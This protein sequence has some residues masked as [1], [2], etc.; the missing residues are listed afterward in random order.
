MPIKNSIKSCLWEVLWYFMEPSILSDFRSPTNHF[1]QRNCSLE[2][3]V[4]KSFCVPWCAGGRCHWIFCT[5]PSSPRCLV[6]LATL[7]RTRI[8][9]RTLSWWTSLNLELEKFTWFL[10]LLERKWQ[11]SKKQ[12]GLPPQCAKPTHNVKPTNLR[13]W[14]F[15]FPHFLSATYF[16]CYWF[17]F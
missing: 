12:G 17:F 16:D 15:W 10:S 5:P 9:E 3:K 4:W 8:S 2:Q 7:V 11:K 14:N 6:Q 13:F 1:K